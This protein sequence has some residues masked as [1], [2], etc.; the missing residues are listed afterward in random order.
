MTW[1]AEPDPSEEGWA[2]T[3]FRAADGRRELWLRS[4]D[5]VEGT[6]HV[7]HL[8]PDDQGVLRVAREEEVTVSDAVATAP[9]HANDILRLTRAVL[10]RYAATGAEEGAR[11]AGE[12][13]E[14]VRELER[15]DVP[16]PASAPDA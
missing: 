7:S 4:G 3:M 11:L 12:L 16:P 6:W 14:A 2:G 15:E 10:D 8:E 5:R 13:G 9:D 1:T